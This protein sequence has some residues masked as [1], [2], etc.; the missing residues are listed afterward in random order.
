MN[1]AVGIDLGTTNTVVGIQTDDTGPEILPVPQ[2]TDRRREFDDGQDWI[3]SAVYFESPT[4]AVAGAWASKRLESFRS[5]KSKM[6]TRWRSKHPINSSLIDAAYVSAH[7]LKLAYQTIIARFPGWDRTA[8]ITVPA[9]FNSAQRSDTLRA[10]KMAGFNE[11]E[12]LDEPTAAFY[13]YFERLRET[14]HFDKKQTVLVFD[15][16]GGTLDVSIIEVQK[17]VDEI[18]IDIIGRSRYNNLGGDDIDLDLAVAMLLCLQA[19]KPEA[20]NKLAIEDLIK[21]LV[22]QASRYKE[23]V[24]DAI[25]E[26]VPDLPEFRIDEEIEAAQGPGH[27]RVSF[28]RT[29]ARS[30]YDEIAGQYFREKSGLNI[31]RPISEALDVA[32]RIRKDFTRE[33]LDLVLTTGGASRMA[34]VQAALSSYFAPRECLPI[35]DEHACHTVALGAAACRH[36]TLHRRR[37][38][39]MTKR[40]L[41][42]LY[43]RTGENNC[44]VPLVPLETEPSIDFHDSPGE[45]FHTLRKLV[46]LVLPLFRGV[47]S[48]DQQLSP[49]G[50][51]NI[52]IGRVLAP[53]TPY[54]I[55]YRV[56]SDMTVDFRVTFATPDGPLVKDTR[57]HIGE[58]TVDA[59]LLPSLAT[60]NAT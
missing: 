47:S 59:A 6:G 45:E 4:S 34:G 28:Q 44:Y 23:E 13:Y 57:V 5:V 19:S 27:M 51:L 18:R 10:A 54:R 32:R 1:P 50:D 33:C 16:G 20:L 30:Q 31:F 38:V 37:T 49:L 52:E 55:Q 8:L 21:I 60:V 46:R 2:P 48:D 36:D 41:E 24:E 22:A 42:T 15:F 25:R 14:D 12:L 35:S 7:V 56:T 39:H 3:K 9:S 53:G 58:E 43:T 11:V 17:V 26:N 29:L 40:L